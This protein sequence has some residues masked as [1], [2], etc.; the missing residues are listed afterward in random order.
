MLRI[1][2]CDGS[3]ECSSRL[4]QITEKIL[5]KGGYRA[6]IAQVTS[7][8]AE[9]VN[10][11]SAAPEDFYLVMTDAV[12]DGS[13]MSGCE[14][15]REIRKL[16]RDCHIVYITSCQEVI[17]EILNSMVRPSGFFIKP[18][19]ENEL[20]ILV[21]DVYR[22]YLNVSAKNC[23]WFYVN[24]GA[25][26]YRI[27]TDSILYFESFDKK[28]YVHTHNQR[29][30][31]YDSL[32][33]LENRLGENFVRCHKSYIINRTKIRSISFSEMTI[34]ME[35]GAVISIS[36]TYKNVIREMFR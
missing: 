13:G 32:A 21:A 31:F 11:I 12:F 30:G 33:N 16:N 35:N 4:A 36:R 5:R 26:L 18:V 15:G 20:E 17:R 19:E 7:D 22:D 14:L 6:E 28:I 1:V 9:V 25:S 8:P 27:P 10:I 2:I 23:E 29:I 34:N 24:I 3:C